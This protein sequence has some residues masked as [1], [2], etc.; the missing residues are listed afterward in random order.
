MPGRTP[1]HSGRSRLSSNRSKWTP[2]S[3]LCAR[4]AR[5][6]TPPSQ[7]TVAF[8]C[9]PRAPLW[10]RPSVGPRLMAKNLRSA[11]RLLDSCAAA[12]GAGPMPHRIEDGLD[13]LQKLLLEMRAGDEVVPPEAARATGLSEDMCRMVLERLANVGLMKQEREGSFVRRPLA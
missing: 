12:H 5:K 9:A 3:T 1:A 4:T 10:K 13:R 6:G 11:Q 8:C 7:P 2:C